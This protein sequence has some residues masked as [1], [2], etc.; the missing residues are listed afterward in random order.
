MSNPYPPDDTWAYIYPVVYAATDVTVYQQDVVI[1]RSEGTSYEE[2]VGVLKVWHVYVGDRCKSDYGDVRFTDASGNALAYYLWP[3]YDSSSA[4]FTVRLEG[5]D[6]GGALMIWY[7]NPSAT[8]TSDGSATYLLF[9]HFD[10]AADAAPNPDIWEV[11]KKGSSSATVKLDGC[12]NLL[13]AGEPN[14]ISSGNVWA[15]PLLSRNVIIEYRDKISDEQYPDTSYGKGGVGGVFDAASN[16]WWHT[17]LFSAYALWV[18]DGTQATMCDIQRTSPATEGNTETVAKAT[19]AFYPSLNTFYT[20]RF[21][22]Q[23]ANLKFYR[24]DVLIASGSDTTYSGDDFRLLFSQGEYSRTGAGGTRTIDYVLVRT[25]SATPPAAT[26]FGPEREVVTPSDMCV[27]SPYPLAVYEVKTGRLPG[28]ANEPIML[29]IP[30]GS[31]TGVLEDFPVM[32]KLSGAS[33]KTAADV[34]KVFVALGSDANRKRICV[35]AGDGITPCYVEI[36]EWNTATQTAYLWV[37]VPRI[38]PGLDTHLYLYYDPRHAEMTDYVGDTASETAWNVWDNGYEFVGIKPSGGLLLDSTRNQNHGTI[39]GATVTQGPLGTCLSFDG[40]DDYIN[41][42]YD[43]SLQVTSQMTLTVL[44]N[45]SG[46]HSGNYGGLWYDNQAS[47]TNRILLRN[48]CRIL[49]EIVIGG[50]M[51]AMMSVEGISADVWGTIAASYDGAAYIHWLNGVA[52][53]PHSASGDINSPTG[54]SR[55]IGR[56]FATTYWYKGEIA[57]VSLSSVARS[58]AWIAATNLSLRDE[59]IVYSDPDA[60]LTL[61]AYVDAYE[62]LSW[63]RRYRRPGAWKCQINRYLPAAKEFVPGRLVHFRRNGE[64]RLGL[65]ETRQISVDTSGRP[66]EVWTVAGREVIGIL[67]DRLCLHGVSTGTGYDVQT[68]PAETVMRHYVD[69][70]AINP[71]DYTRIVPFLSLAQ[72]DGGRGGTTKQSA[73]FDVLTDL[74]ESICAASGLGYRGRWSWDDRRLYFEVINGVDRSA[75]VKLSPALGNC[76]IKGYNESTNLAP[77]VAVVA[78]QGEAADRMVVDVG[79]EAG[80]CGLARRERFIDAR[81][82]TTEADLRQRGAEK[83]AEDGDTTTLEIEYIQTAMYRYGED[84]DIGDIVH[85]EYP[86]IAAMDARIVEIVEEYAREGERLTLVLG[87]EW[88]DL[89]GV[90]RLAQKDNVVKRV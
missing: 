25:Y 2:T 62:Y 40:V 24:D 58:P 26:T 55:W 31:V 75:S 54:K 3:D 64:D 60:P 16:S 12:G 18:Q 15:K 17:G 46:A 84:F 13:L 5:A 57:F 73:R 41:I 33:G 39:Y 69:A 4:R 37:R 51:R 7:G 9:D 89:T 50:V 1:H 35:T 79:K 77:S 38:D 78:G 19:S 70:N 66:S 86:D 67:G 59:L 44:L 53:A 71:A 83:L 61:A 22:V 30:A 20:H 23:S 81:D 87:T 34:S 85:V 63:T 42:P 68:G 65:I 56:G 45:H 43:A 28:W 8:T 32:V 29:T 10:G 48:D 11:V 76:T 80:L 49:S 27:S 74:L 6:Q 47:T 88:P 14:T 90:L 21:E 52:D 82:L 72:V 36:K